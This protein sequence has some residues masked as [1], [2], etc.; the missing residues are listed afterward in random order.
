MAE[1]SPEDVLAGVLRIAVGHEGK[2]RIVPTLSIGETREW[3]AGLARGPAG[4]VVPVSDDDW[5]A[6]TVAQFAGL[7]IDTILD[8]VV[9]YD[10]SGALGGRE[11]LEANADPAQLYRAAVQ[12]AEVAY[13][14][15]TDVPMLLAGLVVVRASVAPSQPRRTN[16]RSRTGASTPVRLRRDSTRAS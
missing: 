11:W 1:R 12:M 8:M 15:A 3:Q 2:E 4:F 10:R 13:P 9:S 6:A 7:S 14:F 16:G 5:T